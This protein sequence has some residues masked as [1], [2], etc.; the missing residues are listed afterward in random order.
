MAPAKLEIYVSTIFEELEKLAMEGNRRDLAI[1]CARSDERSFEP[2]LA[3][4]ALRILG[5]PVHDQV[6]TAQR[7]TVVPQGHVRLTTIHSARGIEA[8]RVVLLDLA[9]GISADDAHLQNSRIMCYIALSRAQRATTIVVPDSSKNP[10][11]TFI[12][13]LNEAY[14]RAM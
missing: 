13:K 7:G 1:I 8:S 3:R 14:S 9:R 5:V 2:R 4:E 11:V 10:Y 6:D 12:E